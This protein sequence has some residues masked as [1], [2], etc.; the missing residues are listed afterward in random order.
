MKLQVRM[1]SDQFELFH[2][3][4]TCSRWGILALFEKR[5]NYLKTSRTWCTPEPF[6]LFSPY[7]TTHIGKFGIYEVSDREVTDLE[8]DFR[9]LEEYTATA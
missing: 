4:K 1:G 9:F 5:N 3:S 7:R 8:Y 2:A 6:G